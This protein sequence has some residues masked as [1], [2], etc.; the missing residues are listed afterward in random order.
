MSCADIQFEFKTGLKIKNSKTHLIAEVGNEQWLGERNER[1]YQLHGPKLGRAVHPQDRVP[2]DDGILLELL[3]RQF[4][5]V[6]ELRL[7]GNL[8]PVAGGVKNESEKRN[9]SG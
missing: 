2:V 5:R 3:L 8:A 4:G 1:Q 9:R 6:Q 7:V